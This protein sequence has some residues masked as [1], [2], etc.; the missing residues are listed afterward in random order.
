MPSN[1]KKAVSFV[2]RGN[3][4]TIHL[5]VDYKLNRPEHVYMGLHADFDGGLGQ[6]QDRIR[7]VGEDYAE[8]VAML[9]LWDEYGGKKVDQNALALITAAMD[10]LRDKRFGSAGDVD[11]APDVS[12]N[13]DV[14]DSR[15]VIKR[16]EVY[17]DAL[18]AAGID[19]D[20]TTTKNFDP[21]SR[22][23]GHEITELLEEYEALKALEDEADG[24]ADWQ[25]G[26]TLVRDDYF[27]DFA[28]QYA[29][30]VGAVNT[31]ARWPNNCIDWKRAADELQSDYS[32]VTFKGVTYWI[33]D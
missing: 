20:E 23:D 21:D 9:D 4:C 31:D 2:V 27:E 13:D 17:Y 30:D 24:A 12:S 22:E 32:A 33:R 14:I 1:I 5:E 7:E 29:E 3:R 11:D 18:D 28:R 26:E 8:V 16:I 19:P 15:D 6:C 10:A 25:Y